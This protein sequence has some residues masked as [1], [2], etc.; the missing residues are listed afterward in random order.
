MQKQGIYVCLTYNFDLVR[1]FALMLFMLLWIILTL[2]TPL[3]LIPLEQLCTRKGWL[4]ILSI[5]SAISLVAAISHFTGLLDV[6]LYSLG[7]VVII[8]ILLTLIY[9]IEIKE[10]LEMKKFINKLVDT[11]FDKLWRKIPQSVHRHVTYFSASSLIA[12][13]TPHGK[14]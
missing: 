13:T 8:L 5:S 11:I 4:P 14:R 10:T 9:S 12:I 6:T 3:W 2:V 1:Y 7:S